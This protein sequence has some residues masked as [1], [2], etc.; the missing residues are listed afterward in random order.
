M[1][2]VLNKK[3]FI[4]L[5]ADMYDMKK[6]DAETCIDIFMTGLKAALEEG[7]EVR[8]LGD[9]H[10]KT[11]QVKERSYPNPKDRSETVTIEAHNKVVCKVGAKIN[12]VVN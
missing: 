8:F 1:G 6:K 9:L 4:T 11:K 12:E 7:N 3:E 2:K 10:F 5:V